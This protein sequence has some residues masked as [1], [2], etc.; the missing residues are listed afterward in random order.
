MSAKRFI[1]ELAFNPMTKSHNTIISCSKRRGTPARF[2][3]VELCEFALGFLLSLNDVYDV[4][5]Q[6][7]REGESHVPFQ[8]YRY[9][10]FS[11]HKRREMPTVMIVNSSAMIRKIEETFDDVP[12]LIGIKIIGYSHSDIEIHQQRTFKSIDLEFSC[13]PIERRTP[14]DETFTCDE[15]AELI[16]DVEQMIIDHIPLKDKSRFQDFVKQLYGRISL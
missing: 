6:K 11:E 5:E 16:C 15:L 7:F 4:C 3:A 9:S 12:Q 8:V 10:D 14:F 1:S 13:D 2:E